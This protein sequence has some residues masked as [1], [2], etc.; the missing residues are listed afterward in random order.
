MDS[1]RLRPLE[2]TRIARTTVGTAVIAG[3]ALDELLKHAL[4][5]SLLALCGD[6]VVAVERG[7]EE[8]DGDEKDRPRTRAWINY[9]RG[10]QSEKLSHRV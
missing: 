8:L 9:E 2:L 3:H 10:N 5:A 7:G 1:P 4:I 6:H